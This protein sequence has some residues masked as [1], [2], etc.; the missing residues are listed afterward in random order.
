MEEISQ[1]TA[2]SA[3]KS[4]YQTG[5]NKLKVLGNIVLLNL[6]ANQKYSINE[7]HDLIKNNISLKV[8]LDVIKTSVK[9]LKKKHSLVEYSELKNFEKKTIEINNEG[10]KRQKEL[11]SDIGKSE[12]E[13]NGLIQKLKSFITNEYKSIDEKEVEEK[14]LIFINRNFNGQYEKTDLDEYIS[15]FFIDIE[16]N[17][18]ANYEK[19]ISLLYGQI[20][21][22]SFSNK[23]VA[24]EANL[25]KMVIYLDTNIVF[26]LFGFHE[27][28]YNKAANDLYELI[29]TK[30]QIS[31]K[32]FEFTKDEISNK[33]LGYSKQYNRYSRYIKVNSIYHILKTRGYSI[34]D[35]TLFVSNIEEELSKKNISIDY[36]SINVETDEKF[37]SKLTDKC[38]TKNELSIKHDAKAINAIRKLRGGG[39][40]LFEK[41]KYIFLTEDSLLNKYTFSHYPHKKY[42]TISEAICISYLTS[43]MWLRMDEEDDNKAIFYSFLAN[44]TRS[45][46]IQRDNY[47]AV[48]DILFEKE[49]EGK[50]SKAGIHEIISMK[51]TEEILKNNNDPQKAVEI[52]LS[53][54]NIGKIKREKSEKNALLEETTKELEKQ[55]TK[56]LEIKNIIGDDCKAKWKGIKITFIIAVPFVIAIPFIIVLYS[57]FYSFDIRNLTVIL[58]TPIVYWLGIFFKSP[59]TK[60]IKNYVNDFFDK[61]IENCIIKKRK[62]I[63]L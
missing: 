2:L 12:R 44:Y 4:F 36:S 1:I 50:I 62:K 18:Q 48:I 43:I 16:K 57:I 15:K 28:Y 46:M 61:R 45:H 55:Q 27:E 24:Y 23:N 56:I 20:V 51:E 9:S 39:K 17:D 41:C 6:K 34:E 29:Q 7:I 38:N 8:P 26:S 19:L 14:L 33:L 31:F 30:Q 35:I 37:V 59:F 13:K 60:T 5:H 58:I 49:R 21:F 22:N 32:I 25:D 63:N 10:I 47:N 52:I 11:N 40:I 42:G 54:G 53:D 3:V